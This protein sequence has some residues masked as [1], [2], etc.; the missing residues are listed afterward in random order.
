MGKFRYFFV[1]LILLIIMNGCSEEKEEIVDIDALV[2]EQCGEEPKREYPD[3]H[4]S[5]SEYYGREAEYYNAYYPY[6]NCVD[7]IYYHYGNN[8]NIGSDADYDYDEGDRDEESKDGTH[9]VR[10]HERTLQN[11]ETIW[12]DG[13]GDTSVDLDVEEGGG[14]YQSNP[15]P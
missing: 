3:E 6:R 1:S 4:E 15:S 2:L 10:P 9:F 5:D 7:S 14:W 12:V 11:G 8:E 13:D